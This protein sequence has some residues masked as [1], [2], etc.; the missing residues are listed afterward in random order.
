MRT[1]VTAALATAHEQGVIHRDVKPG[2][3]MLTEG[4]GV[5]VLDFGIARASGAEPP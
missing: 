2:N 5:E 3:L 1:G 4:G